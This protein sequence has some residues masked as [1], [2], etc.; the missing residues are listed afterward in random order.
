M[1]ARRTDLSKVHEQIEVLQQEVTDLSK[2][3][4]RLQEELNRHPSDSA[5]AAALRSDIERLE[6][7]VAELR[8]E[9][10]ARLNP[11]TERR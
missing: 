10:T 4:L 5:E 8:A 6:Q 7:Q 11:N 2:E 9:L 3:T 1:V